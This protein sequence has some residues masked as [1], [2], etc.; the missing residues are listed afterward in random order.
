VCPAVGVTAPAG[1][2]TIAVMAY[3]GSGA[4]GTLLA[5]GKT[6]AKV[7]SGQTTP[8]GISIHGR[9]ANVKLAL[10]DA[11]PPAGS[12]ASISLTSASTDSDGYYIVGTYS[13]PIG[14][15]AS[16]PAKEVTLSKTRLTG[17][18]DAITLSYNGKGSS[19]VTLT[20][21]ASTAQEGALSLT[22]GGSYDEL[23]V[24]TFSTGTPAC[25][26]DVYDG[27][28]NGALTA[29][30]TDRGTG[31]NQSCAVAAV[32]PD[33]DV[34]LAGN[35]GLY[36][37]NGFL[38]QTSTFSYMNVYGAAGLHFDS[39]GKMYAD[40]S[41]IASY[42]DS[43]DGN[44]LAITVQIFAPPFTGGVYPQT[45]VDIPIADESYSVD[46]GPY[47]VAS[48][49]DRSGNLW[50]P[51]SNGIDEFSIVN[52]G[53]KELASISYGSE[54]LGV[55]G[56]AFGPKNVLWICDSTTSTSKVIELKAGAT[57]A[58]APVTTITGPYVAGCAFVQVD[59]AGNVYVLTHPTVSGNETDE[60]NVFPPSASGSATPSRSL[61]L[62]SGDSTA[63][64]G[65]LD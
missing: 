44:A 2:D 30:A 64:F 43:K 48:V 40:I 15:S 32:A 5:Q 9:V 1:T 56:M 41:N 49:T 29:K 20:G 7:T 62:D 46:R 47:S 34:Y 58:N 54:L 61:Q 16:D 26:L 50:L 11:A 45:S 57:T 42:E 65:L 33:G 53:S 55:T 51:G 60:I 27:A 52:G 31:E 13:N 28:A 17:S 38:A 23:V 4:S 37:F 18:T 21:K 39:S 19:T 14:I 24:A 3:D 22:P 63:T 59:T 36:G 6:T 25:G 8:V 10:S 12:S 35:T